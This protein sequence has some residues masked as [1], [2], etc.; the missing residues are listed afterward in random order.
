MS[1]VVL[2]ASH[3]DHTQAPDAADAIFS[4]LGAVNPHERVSSNYVEG[5]YFQGELAG[6]TIEVSVGDSDYSDLPIWIVFN[7]NDRAKV[8]GVV[9]ASA[10]D[11][12]RARFQLA[13]LDNFG[14]GDEVRVDL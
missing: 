13:R 8:E 11:L 1:I 12:K 7:G 6:V 9:N 14:R 4:A 10:N 5:R 3:D 2:A